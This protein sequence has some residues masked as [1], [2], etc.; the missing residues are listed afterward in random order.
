MATFFEIF[1]QFKGRKFHLSGESYAVCL[2]LICLVTLWSAKL[3][4]CLFPQGRYLP[5]Y[6][7]AILDQNALLEAQGYTPI[8]LKSI[9]IGT[10][11]VLCLNNAHL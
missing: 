11:L 4:S 8:S 9:I 10:I 6:A 7:A 5:V 1:S 3:T 2:F